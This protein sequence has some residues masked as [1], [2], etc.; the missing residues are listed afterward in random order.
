[1]V[2]LLFY[3]GSSSE[4][5]AWMLPPASVRLAWA[6][7]PVG[8]SRRAVRP[9]IATEPQR[10]T[11]S[12]TASGHRGMT[13]SHRLCLPLTGGESQPLG[14]A[15]ELLL[16]RVLD[17]G[18]RDVVVL[19][20]GELTQRVRAQLPVGEEAAPGVQA[21]GHVDHKAVGQERPLAGPGDERRVG[22]HLTQGEVLWGEGP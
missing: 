13:S 21:S 11:H 20:W 6:P 9:S 16:P 2:P 10:K 4:F 19:A 12:E 7:G 17:G 5:S 3:L 18:Q 22:G 1:M 15:V 14:G 8:R